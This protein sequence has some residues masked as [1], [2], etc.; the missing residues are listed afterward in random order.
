MDLLIK[1]SK[2]DKKVSLATFK[3]TE[4]LRFEVEKVD[5]DKIRKIQNQPRQLKLNL[6]SFW[7]VKPAKPL[8][9][10]FRYCLKI[11]SVK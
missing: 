1:A 6:D 7:K 11:V 3:P 10:L 9:Y 4:I 8:P 2:S 5:E